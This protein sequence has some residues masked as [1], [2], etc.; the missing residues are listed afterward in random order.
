MNCLAIACVVLVPWAVIA[1]ACA[2][3]SS[4]ECAKW[5][6]KYTTADIMR[7]ML[8]DMDARSSK[9]LFKAQE[10]LG[11]ARRALNRI[12]HTATMAQLGVDCK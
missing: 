3:Y 10:E 5:R 9:M 8:R 7:N 12:G 6:A 4:R 11:V 2:Y 1:T